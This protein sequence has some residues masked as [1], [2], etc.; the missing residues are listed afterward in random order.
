VIDH[1]I[2]VD[3]AMVDR[4]GPESRF[5]QEKLATTSLSQMCTAQFVKGDNGANPSSPNGLQSRCGNLG[6]NLVHNTTNSGGAPLSLGNLD[7]IMWNVNK[8]THWLFPRGLMP[9]MDIAA[10]NNSLVNQTISFGQ[11]DFGR[12]ITMYKG[13][14]IL[15]GYEPDDSPD[16]LPFTEVAVGG[17]PAQTASIYCISLRDGGVYGIEQTALSVNDQGEMPGLPFLSTHIKWDWGIA[18]EHP[19]AIARLDSITAATIVA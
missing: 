18:R 6:Y 10:R 1:Y 3:R 8:P 19:R 2:K 11:D 9:Y 7:L 13:L 12:R 17:G 15:F 4:L 14:P 16:M 5:K